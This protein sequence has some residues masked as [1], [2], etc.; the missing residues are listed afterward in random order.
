MLISASENPGQPISVVVKLGVQVPNLR[1]TAICVWL[2][3]YCEFLALVEE[4]CDPGFSFGVSKCRSQTVWSRQVS[5]IFLT[6]FQFI[7]QV[8]KRWMV[9][10]SG[11]THCSHALFKLFELISHA[12][13]DDT[14]DEKKEAHSYHCSNEE[15][16]V[17]FTSTYQW[18]GAI[19]SRNERKMLCINWELG[20]FP[21]PR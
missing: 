5:D 2:I 4:T 9:C 3:K 11:G 10:F 8:W 17:N 14:L 20:K 6:V 16:F 1:R 18:I 19:S 21:S 7:S 13:N 15:N 12:G